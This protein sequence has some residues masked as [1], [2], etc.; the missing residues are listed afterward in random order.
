MSRCRLFAWPL[1][2]FLAFFTGCGEDDSPT[3]PASGTPLAVDL[4]PGV[5]LEMV[6]IAPGTF[7]MGSPESEAGR[8]AVEGPRHRVRIRDGFYLGRY[9]ITQAQWEAVMGTR[10]WADQS[11]VVADPRNPATHV[12]WDD[13]QDFVARLNEGVEGAPYRLPTEAEWEYACRAGTTTPWYSGDDEADLAAHAWYSVTAWQTD[14][15]YAHT[16]GS[17]LTNPWGLYDMHG[18]VLEW[19]L[20]YWSD[21]GYPA[22]SQTDPRGPETGVNRVYRGGSIRNSALRMRSATRYHNVP[23]FRHGFVGLRILREG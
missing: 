23:S 5:S 13:A 19:T 11:Y 21:A 10:P 2:A 6:W 1:M 12:S 15:Q 14:E 9:E 16:V 22:T 3:G 8:E 18:N 7:Q 4:A 20:D 17:K